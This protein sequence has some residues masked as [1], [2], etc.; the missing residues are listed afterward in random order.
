M[1]KFTLLLAVIGLLLTQTV[2]AQNIGSYTRYVT[3]GFSFKL[4]L[5]PGDT[6]GDVKELQRVLNADPDT[7]IVSSSNEGTRGRENTY[8]DSNTKAAVI[9]FQEKHRDTVLTPVGLTSGTGNVGKYTRTKLNLLIGVLETKDSVGSPDS[10]PAAVTVT[11]K[12]A[13]SQGLTNTEI[14]QFIELL[15]T[16]GIIPA[17]R[18]AQARLAITTL[19]GTTSTAAGLGKIDLKINGQDGPVTVTYGNTYAT[20]TWVGTN[21]SSCSSG[22]AQ[23]PT[24]GT[25][26]VRIDASRTYTLTCVG[27]DGKTVS[28]TATVYVPALT[29]TVTY[30]STATNYGPSFSSITITPSSNSAKFVFTTDKLTSLRVSYDTNPDNFVSDYTLSGTF[31]SYNFSL[32][33]LSAS[34]TY[35]FKLIATDADGNKRETSVSSFTTTASGTG[36]DVSISSASAND[37]NQKVLYLSGNSGDVVLVDDSSNL[38]MNT[39]L[40]LEAW[41]RPIAYRTANSMGRGNQVIV[42]KGQPLG[43]RRVE[44]AMLIDNGKLVFNGSVANRSIWTC[45]SVVPLNTWTHVAVAVNDTAGTVNFYVNGT[46]VTSICEGNTSGQTGNTFD[47]TKSLTS[48]DSGVTIGNYHPYYCDNTNYNSAFTGYIDDVRIWNTERTRQ[49]IIDNQAST[50]TTATGLVARYTFDD[51]FVADTS[52]LENDGLLK[53]FGSIQSL[54]SSPAPVVFSGSLYNSVQVEDLACVPPLAVATTTPAVATTTA[55]TTDTRDPHNAFGGVVT[56]VALCTNKNTQGHTLFQVSI[57]ACSSGDTTAEPLYNS[58][59][60]STT[61]NI[62]VTIREGYQT[63]PRVGQTVLGEAVPDGA[64]TCNGVATTSLDVV[65]DYLAANNPYTSDSQALSSSEFVS[66]YSTLGTGQ[67]IG[68]VS[69]AMG[70]GI[71]CDNT[72]TV[73]ATSGQTTSTETEDAK[74]NTQG[75][76]CVSYN[77]DRSCN[78][79]GDDWDK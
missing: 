63:L 28:D 53:G 79:A 60:I 72:S 68:T 22:S 66:A 43:D 17:D 62:Y 74:E 10:R 49:Q 71:S 50:S 5:L 35:Y 67:Y 77:R 8:F 75:Y 78:V 33:Y 41:V 29:G 59:L 4:D 48:S 9:K 69:G 38:R 19:T 34:T 18:A 11:A 73:A 51:S 13:A 12:P 44:Y 56:G 42:A 57:K 2:S 15:I 21:V 70:L 20:F 25:Q 58:D 61:G 26:Q 55:T 47:K 46:T 6:D 37:I 39:T 54:T 3:P 16:L 65:T 27:T 30:S 32:P 52:G 14:R 31:T 24:S 36:S 23:K 7:A 45:S 76:Q 1:N 64:G 40:T